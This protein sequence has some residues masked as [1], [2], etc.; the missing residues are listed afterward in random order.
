M[1]QHVRVNLEWELSGYTRGHLSGMQDSD[2]GAPL[3]RT[4]DKLDMTISSLRSRDIP[5]RAGTRL[6]AP[7]PHNNDLDDH[8]PNHQPDHT[9]HTVVDHQEADHK[10]GYH[11]CRTAE[12]VAMPLARSLIS[13]GNSSGETVPSFKK[14]DKLSTVR[15]TDQF[16][17]ID[18][19]SVGELAQ[20]GDARRDH[21]AFD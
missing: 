21:S 13:V 2:N 8:Q 14:M 9:R 10:G 12:R 4:Q 1:P 18:T 5:Q 19:Q 6:D 20:D 15:G 7:E 11:G 3:S 16:A 17:G